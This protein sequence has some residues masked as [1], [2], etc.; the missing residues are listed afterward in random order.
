MDAV[1][2]R[3]RRFVDPSGP[4]PARMMAA[5]GMVPVKGGDLVLLLAQLTVDPDPTV[6]QS[7][8]DT[9]QELPE[10]VLLP[11]CDEDLHAAVF[12]EVALRFSTHDEVLAR[13]AQNH[14]VADATIAKISTYCPERITEIISVNQQRLLGAPQIIEALYKNRNTRMSTADRLVEL[15]ARHEVD[16]TG[17]PMFDELKKAIQGQLIPEASEEPLPADDAFSKALEEDADQ[18]AVERDKVDGTEETKEEFVSLQAKIRG[19]NVGE[20]IRLALLGNAAARSMLVRDPNRVVCMAAIA[21]PAM[22]ESEAKNAAQSREVSEDVLRFIAKKREWIRNYEI[23]RHLC[24]N[25]KTPLALSM[26]FLAHLRRNDLRALSRSRG[27]PGPLKQ[28]A[29]RRAK[30]FES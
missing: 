18:D 25:P 4:V 17:I 13:L 20:K 30:N 10:A 14:A 1:P 12:H 23:K 21:S 11:A 26:T 5:R 8:G 2:E 27:V 6:S 7:A 16:L 29:K 3:L 15:A 22:G 28:A 19:M 9:L 24:N